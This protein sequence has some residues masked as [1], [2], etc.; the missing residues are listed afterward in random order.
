MTA[1]AM[2][3]KALRGEPLDEWLIIDA[4]A[5]MGQSPNF[6]VLDTRPE[7]VIAAMDRMGVDLLFFSQMEGVFGEARRGNRIAEA[8]VRAYPDRLCAYLTVD[9]GYPDLVA[10]E[11]AAA[12]GSDFRAIK[13][14]SCGDPARIPYDHPNYEPVYAF[15]EEHGFPILAHTWGR[16]ALD[17]LRPAI[18]RYPHVNWLLAHAAAEDKAAYID[19]ATTCPTVYLELC[20]SRCPRGG[21]ED[22]VHAGL[23]DKVVWGSDAV[24]MDAA[25]QL[26]R[27]VFAQITLEDKIKILGL[28][29]KRVLRP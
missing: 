7:S 18:A 6:P 28:N 9:A 20:Y 25:Q 8:T 4:H 11:L 15:A 22:L 26:G 5:H 13:I 14:W 24:F 19:I 23:A 17:Q 29:A 10:A 12:A 1:D 3:E 2:V 27:V 16:R 21:V